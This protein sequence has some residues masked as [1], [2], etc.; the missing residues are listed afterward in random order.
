[1]TMTVQRLGPDDWQLWRDARLAALADTPQAFASSLEREQA[2]TE[3]RWREW[4][5]PSNH[6]KAAARQAP[7]GAT[8]GVIGAW[9]PEDRGG[10]AELYSM[11]VHP[12]RRGHGVGDLLVA[13]VRQWAQ[14]QEVKAVE[15]WVVGDNEAA[16][17][18]Y[19]RH[20]F[21]PTGESQPYPPNP[22]LT[23]YV[24]RCEVL[25]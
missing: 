6:L 10:A 17:R 23:E 5:D 2:Y 25:S 13:E 19:A 24:M 8:A 11:W 15:L 21:T 20:G 22:A 7:H 18:L 16:R 3:S 4:L 1:M 14:E 12:T 9:I